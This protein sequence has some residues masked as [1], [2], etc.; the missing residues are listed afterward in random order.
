MIKLMRPFL[1]LLLANFSLFTESPKTTLSSESI[2]QHNPLLAKLEPKLWKR[3]LAAEQAYKK[4]HK[5][6]DNFIRLVERI[7][8]KHPLKKTEEYIRLGLVQL[9]FKD[10]SIEIPATLNYPKE[11]ILEVLLCNTSGRAHE[12]LFITDARPL[13]LELI[14]HYAGF[15]K[16]LDSEDSFAIFVRH[17]DNSETPVEQFFKGTNLPKKQTWIFEG[18]L[19]QEMNYP[20]D[21]NGELILLWKSHDSVLQSSSEDIRLNSTEILVNKVKKFSHRQKIT[22]ILKAIKSSKTTLPNSPLEGK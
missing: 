14:L 9:N 15:S 7:S 6:I 13:H 19:Y 11:K 5:N 8:K 21:T 3:L 1:L 20:P 10:K 12:T 17:A 18:S 22:V 2:K 16:K 4:D